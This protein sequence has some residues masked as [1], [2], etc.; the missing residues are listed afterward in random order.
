MFSKSVIE[1]IGSYVYSLCDPST[2]EVFYIGKGKGNRV[3]DHLKCSLDES[4]NSNKLDRIRE[5]TSKGL[6]VEHTILRH[7]LTDDE[8]ILIEAVLIDFAGKD[9]LSNEVKGHY[10]SDFGAKTASEIIFQYDAKPC[11]IDDKVIII[12]VNRQ[13][14]QTMTEQ[15][16]YEITRGWWVIG[17]RRN[18]AE[19]VISAY[20][21]LVREIYQI[22]SWES[23][24]FGEKKRRAFTGKVASEEIR[25]KY[26]NT[27]L[28]NYIVKGAQ[29]PIKYVNC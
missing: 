7:G 3:F 14:K 23:R 18:N 5:I 10:S 27:S 11:V 22:D 20:N 8:A 13:F 26:K 25:E 2:K 28:E 29:N 17:E 21:G 12:T 19:Y 24:A 6:E 16:L 1:K 4:L 9:N 15:E